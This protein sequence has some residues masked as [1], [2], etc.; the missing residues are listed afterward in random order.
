LAAF[1]QGSATVKVVLQQ[2]CSS[3]WSG[4][5]KGLASL[6]DVV[7]D[8]RRRADVVAAT[9]AIGK[10]VSERLEDRNHRVRGVVI[11][12]T[13]DS[14]CH[15]HRRARCAA[16]ALLLG[17]GGCVLILCTCSGSSGRLEGFVHL[18]RSEVSLVEC[19]PRTLPAQTRVSNR[20]WCAGTLPAL[21]RNLPYLL[22]GLPWILQPPASSVLEI[23]TFRPR[24]AV[25][26]RV[27]A[28]HALRWCK[29]RWRWRPPLP[30]PTPFSSTACLKRCSR[31]WC[32]T[33]LPATLSTLPR[34]RKSRRH[35]PPPTT[36]TTLSCGV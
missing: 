31:G 18:T 6:A 35:S 28:A 12:P 20:T 1:L 21:S 36:S 15:H 27:S 13:T 14:A 22:C 2:C 10:A 7:A 19:V 4:R 26:V 29:P 34:P 23:R 9:E 5:V 11:P 33:L 30:A 25:R 8:G 17:E 16:C 3:D 32:P 24:R